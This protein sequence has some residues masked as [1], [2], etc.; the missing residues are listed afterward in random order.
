MLFNSI[1]FM[2]VFLPVTLVGYFLTRRFAPWSISVCWLVGASL[3]F[4]GC[5][6]PFYVPLLVVS[7]LINFKVG[8]W[9][10]NSTTKH[11]RRVLLG[12]GIGANLMCLSWFKYSYFFVANLTSISGVYLALPNIILPLGISFFTFQQIAYLIDCH[13]EEAEKTN[14]LSYCLFVTFFPQLIAGPIV[15][16]KEMLPQF[17]G[18]AKFLFKRSDLAVGFTI[19]AIGLFKKVVIADGIA[20]FA[21]PVFDQAGGGH[22][23][24]F[25]SAWGAALSYTFQLYFDFSAYS[26]MAVGIGRMFGVRLPINFFSPYKSTSIIEFWRCW[27]MTLS[28]FLRDYLYFPLGGNRLG[29]ARRY[30]NLMTVMIIGGLWHGAGWTFVIWGALHGIYLVINHVWAAILCQFGIE[31]IRK[32]IGYRFFAW[33]ITFLSVV[34]SWVLFRAETLDAAVEIFIG[35]AGFNG[36]ALPPSFG[37]V[38]IGVFGV[39]GVNISIDPKIGDMNFLLQFLWIAAAGTIAFWFPNTYEWISDDTIIL[40]SR[41]DKTKPSPIVWPVW[42]LHQK[43]RIIQM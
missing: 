30:I 21:T 4:Y 37:N 41:I 35:M 17:S 12:V 2:G 10:L 31:S 3:V 43:C 19:F 16:H 36:S 28:R 22:E 42:K 14:F 39:S 13:R 1:E 38:L 33:F 5:W 32:L 8:E 20:E 29:V 26:D 15:H 24:T 6:N 34:I 9:L 11:T 23:I 18:K 25:F 40:K 7:V 27:H